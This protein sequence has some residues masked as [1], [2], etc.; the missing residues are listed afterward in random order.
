MP[1]VR[2]VIVIERALLKTPADFFFYSHVF[3]HRSL[4]L[5]GLN[6]CR[7]KVN[8]PHLVDGFLDAVTTSIRRKETGVRR[9]DIW[10][11]D[12]AKSE[13]HKSTRLQDKANRRRAETTPE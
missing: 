4:L 6:G 1:G 7:L 3:G 2:P 13:S 10:V 12:G 8:R 9:Q 5:F 11:W